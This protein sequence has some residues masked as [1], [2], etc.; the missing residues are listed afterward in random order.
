MPVKSRRSKSIQPPA[1][2]RARYYLR[3][4]GKALEALELLEGSS[5][6]IALPEI[7]R[8]LK[9]SKTSA[10]RVLCTLEMAGYVCVSAPGHYRVAPE[11]CRAASNQLVMRLMR[12]APPV[13]HQ[14]SRELRET[15]S[16]AALFENRVEVIASVDSPELVRMGNVIG[17]IVPPNASSVGKVVT[18]FQ[19]EEHREKL[20]RS[21]GLYRFTANTITDRR[22]L[23][24]EYASICARR[25]AADREES[26]S[27]GYCFAVPIFDKQGG[28][29]AGISVSLPKCRYRDEAQEKTFCA[30]LEV[31]AEQITRAIYPA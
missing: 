14:L 22:L 1:A 26:V 16:V 28:V 29:P 25:F 18:A 13:M 24:A 5:S 12:E 17:H 31:A 27:D 6:G 11:P 15:V 7:A 8:A 23:E 21:Y 3:A 9:L 2:D 4:V 30:A 20:L 19:P 10:F